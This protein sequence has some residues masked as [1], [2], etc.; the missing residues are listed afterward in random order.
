MLKRGSREYERRANKL[1]R[2][3]VNIQ[4]CKKCG[5]PT[6]EGYCC[7]TCGDGNPYWTQEQEDA[8]KDKYTK[9]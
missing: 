2:S 1:A 9:T 3:F 7:T 4:Q 8:W 5:N 6:V